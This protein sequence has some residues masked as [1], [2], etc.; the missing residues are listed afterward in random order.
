MSSVTLA[1][2]AKLA[3]DELVAGVIENIITVNRFFD[4]L[5]FDGIE[6]NS[7]AYNREN[8]LGDV[9]N[10]GV[11][12]TFS[13]AGA[14]KNPATFTRVNSNLTTIMGDAEVNGLIQATRSG[15]GNDQTAVQIASKAKSAGRQYQNQLING[16]GTN[17]E[18]AGLL[19]LVASG[20]TLTPQTN[21]QALSFEIL[22]E[23][24]DRVVD[25]DG[26]VDYITMHARTLRSYKALLR[27]LGGASINEVV[28]LPSGAEVP[29]YSGVPIF[30]NDY[31][32]T[33]QT[34]GNVSTATTIFAGTLDDGSRT[35]G[36]AGLTATTAAGIQV[37]DVGESEDADEH[38]WRVK[39]YCGLAL[40]S[41]KGL[42]AAPGITN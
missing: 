3:Q 22:D 34:Q 33:N 16:T 7:L 1:E 31:I 24:M 35:H 6:G 28:E 30:R 5:P 26:Q 39:W 2:S 14:G 37:V 17:N 10:A 36:I 20:Q 4:V 29:A 12:T 8:V 21:G 42:A 32:P 9:I 15:D 41:E 40:F 13:A 38:I 25:K 23:L 19:Q 11:G 18:F 27:N